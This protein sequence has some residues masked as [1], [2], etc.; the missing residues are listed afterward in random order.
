MAKDPPLPLLF[1]QPEKEESVKC[2]KTFIPKNI[3]EKN[4]QNFL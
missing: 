3:S 1:C 2:E 4:C